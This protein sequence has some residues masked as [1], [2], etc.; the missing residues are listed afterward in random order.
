M[1]L[2]EAKKSDT[3]HNIRLSVL[4]NYADCYMANIMRNVIMLTVIILNIV[5]LKNMLNI[6]TLNIVMLDVITLT[7]IVLNVAILTAI[8]LSAFIQNVI[9]LYVVMVSVAAPKRK[10]KDAYGTFLKRSSFFLFPSTADFN[11]RPI[12]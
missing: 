5:M 10:E 8:I 6:I 9:M 12:L 7:V 4:I 3:Q 2:S 11:R 1:T